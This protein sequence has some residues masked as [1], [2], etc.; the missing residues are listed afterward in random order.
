WMLMLLAA[1]VLVLLIAC[2]NVANLWLARASGQQRDTAVRAALGA[3]RGRL[4]QRVLIESLV[5]SVGGTLM[6]LGLGWAAV[7]LLAGALPQTVARVRAIGIDARV[8]AV[9][10][11][12]A[13][14]TGLLSGLVPAVQGARPALLTVLGEARAGAG[15]GRRRARAALVVVEVALAVVLL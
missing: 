8:L 3:S 10:A 11:A 14:A 1:V 9:A 6:G 15:R 12:V 13:L 5:V 4:V 2:A 7:G